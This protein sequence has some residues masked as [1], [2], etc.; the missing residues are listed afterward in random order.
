MTALIS[1]YW[2]LTPRLRFAPP[3][4]G[5]VGARIF[6]RSDTADRL[7][8]FGLGVHT[9]RPAALSATMRVIARVHP[10]SANLRPA[11][12]P[13]LAPGLADSNILMIGITDLSG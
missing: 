3:H 10:P 5:A 1:D 2:H 4:D 9:D 8:P 6:P 11:S 12:K 13:A 7:A